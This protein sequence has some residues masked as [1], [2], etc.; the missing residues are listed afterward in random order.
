MFL[1]VY[2]CLVHK[3]T[4]VERTFETSFAQ[5]KFHCKSSGVLARDRGVCNRNE[6]LQREDYSCFVLREA[7]AEVTEALDCV[8]PW[9]KG[10]I[11]RVPQTRGRITVHVELPL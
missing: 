6:T 7:C 3:T 5:G 10:N 2:I 1:N 8:R 4:H 11:L 9:R